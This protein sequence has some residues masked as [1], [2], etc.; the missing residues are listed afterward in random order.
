MSFLNSKYPCPTINVTE[1]GKFTRNYY[2]LDTIQEFLPKGI[3][4]NRWGSVIFSEKYPNTNKELFESVS[5]IIEQISQLSKDK[6]EK[7]SVLIFMP[8]LAEIE[9]LSD[10]IVQ[11]FTRER[12][13]REFEIINVHSTILNDKITGKL[14]EKT[15]KKHKIIISTNIAESSITVLGV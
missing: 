9:N 14:L 8:G 6:T 11:F 3:N 13:D 4:S 12:V 1:P 2:Y 15:G 5:L 7:S 10:Y